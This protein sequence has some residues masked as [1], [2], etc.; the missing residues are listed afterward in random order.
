MKFYRPIEFTWHGLECGIGFEITFWH[1]QS[2]TGL[3]I[4]LLVLEIAI[5]KYH[6]LS[7]KHEK[8]F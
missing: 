7:E 6:F 2:W 3:Q 4:K 1:T 5:G 8:R